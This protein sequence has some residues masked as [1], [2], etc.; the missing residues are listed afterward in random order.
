ML[1]RRR[2]GG[3]Q[4]IHIDDLRLQRVSSHVR[5]SVGDDAVS[6]GESH[7]SSG[8]DLGTPEA[9]ESFDDGDDLNLDEIFPGN[10]N[11]SDEELEDVWASLG[12]PVD[13][14][15]HDNNEEPFYYELQ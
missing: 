11:F 13:P 14:S 7:S 9:R 6:F 2:L 1:C 3:I 8:E 12:I 10:F 5:Y 4:F 15:T